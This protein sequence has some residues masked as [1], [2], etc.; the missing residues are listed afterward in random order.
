MI[1]N[2]LILFH[3]FRAWNSLYYMIERAI[4]LDR[5]DRFCI[6][7]AETMRGLSTVAY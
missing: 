4:K 2:S 1:L 6:D 3:D 7:Y 5:I